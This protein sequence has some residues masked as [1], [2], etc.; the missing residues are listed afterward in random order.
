MGIP[1]GL[2]A[3]IAGAE[4]S[5]GTA[6]KGPSI[7]NAW[8][9]MS[10]YPTQ[11]G[12][13]DWP[14]AIKQYARFLDQNYIEEGLNTPS[15]IERKYV[16]YASPDWLRNVTTYQQRLGGGGPVALPSGSTNNNGARTANFTPTRPN[17]TPTLQSLAGSFGRTSDARNRLFAKMVENNKRI[18]AGVLPDSLGLLGILSEINQYAEISSNNNETFQFAPAAKNIPTEV[19]KGGKG[20]YLPAAFTAD[21]P[22]SGLEGF[23]A[24]DFMAAAGTPVYAPFSGVVDPNRP[25]GWSENQN[26]A[27]GF[28]GARMYL[29][30][31]ADQDPAAET[32]YLAHMAKNLQ[33]KP[34]Q[35]IKKG[36]LLGY[37]WNWTN[38]PGRS[39]VH[40]GLSGAG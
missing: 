7:F 15:E 8:G 1:K 12:F 29:T 32:A 17:R 31:Q 28:G 18:Q 4:T 22:T 3:S 2:I 26:A 21:H 16:G 9:W 35:K 30:G 34:G 20:L 14:T 19:T 36:Q 25:F 11:R 13:K 24:N 33:V 39:H 38:D 40:Y 37:V 27:A 5:F 6:G 23:P 10:D